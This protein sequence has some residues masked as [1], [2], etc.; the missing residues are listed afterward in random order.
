M[1]SYYRLLILGATMKHATPETIDAIAAVLGIVRARPE[2]TERKH[3]TFYRK[4]SAFLH[5]HEDP[6]GLFADVKGAN[7]WERIQVD[8]PGGSAALLARVHAILG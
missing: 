7:G 1:P 4:A 6:A 2:L 8:A 5:F 3:G